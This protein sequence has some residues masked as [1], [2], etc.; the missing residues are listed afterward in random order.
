MFGSKGLAPDG[1]PAA[2]DAHEGIT[3]EAR[4]RM[5]T[6]SRAKSPAIAGS[7]GLQP[8]DRCLKFAANR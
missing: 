5:E 2:R 7:P 1:E 4:G 8:P 6:A 3:V